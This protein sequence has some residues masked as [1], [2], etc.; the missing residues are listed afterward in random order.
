M[1]TASF[2]TAV[3]IR[4][5]FAISIISAL[6]SGY[7][8]PIP[9][10]TARISRTTLRFFVDTYIWTNVNPAIIQCLCWSSLILI[11]FGEHSS[12]C[13]LIDQYIPTGN[14]S[15]NRKSQSGWGCI[16]LRR[17]VTLVATVWVSMIRN[18]TSVLNR[19]SYFFH[20]GTSN[21]CW[22]L[23]PL[24]YHRPIARETDWPCFLLVIRNLL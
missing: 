16:A 2:S 12:E 21:R 5:A 4:R 13:N 17:F 10:C 15:D 9:M 20:F 24:L 7:V 18:Y 23:P 3:Y 1:F 8:N 6:L 11:R 19:S 22:K 14:V